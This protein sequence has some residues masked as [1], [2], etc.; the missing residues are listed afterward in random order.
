MRVAARRRRHT[1][2][3]NRRVGKATTVPRHDEINEHLA[4]RICRA[5]EVRDP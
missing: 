2:Y 4:R 1:V 3:V 5:L